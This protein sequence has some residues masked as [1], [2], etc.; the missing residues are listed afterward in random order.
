MSLVAIDTNVLF[1][2][3]NDFDVS[4]QGV[5][6]DLLERAAPTGVVSLQA[7]AE[8]F[9]VVARK[10]PEARDVGA[11]YIEV[12]R[13][14]FRMVEAE[15]SDLDDAIALHRRHHINFWDAMLVASYRRAG[16]SIL[17][18]EDLQHGRDFGGLR[19]VNPFLPD[20]GLDGLFHLH[21]EPMPWRPDSGAPP[22]D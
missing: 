13:Q 20:A 15:L 21:E 7:L 6:L 9:A 16:A 17:L 12:W 22:P 1:Y 10:A 11:T 3:F 5:A 14:T 2:A 4:K 18:S 19:I 8:F